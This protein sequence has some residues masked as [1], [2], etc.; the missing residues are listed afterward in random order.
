[1][2]ERTEKYL[3]I[4]E[5]LHFQDNVEFLTTQVPVRENGIAI[6]VR[7]PSFFLKNHSLYDLQ[8]QV[9]KIPA[10]KSVVSQPGTLEATR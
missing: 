4:L 6:I 3:I 1:M 2:Q 8:M 10:G 9:Q 5:N 7:A